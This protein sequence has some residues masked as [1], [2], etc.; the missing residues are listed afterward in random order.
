MPTVTE[1]PPPVSGLNCVMVFVPLELAKKVPGFA[2]PV[3]TVGSKT[4]PV[5]V[6]ET[7][8]EEVVVLRTGV[9]K[10]IS[11]TAREPVGPLSKPS[12]SA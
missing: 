7:K 12:A 10:P 2:V 11:T 1:L 8:P 3:V 9:A 6:L 4:M 5:G